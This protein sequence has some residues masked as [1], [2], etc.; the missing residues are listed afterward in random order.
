MDTVQILCTLRIVK[1]Y[2]GV[3][4]SDIPQNSITRSGTVIINAD[5]H[6]EKGSHWVAIHFLPRASSAYYFASYVNSPIVRTL[7]SFL[8]SNCAV[9][10]YNTVHLQGLTRTVYSQYCY[11]F[12]LNMD[13]CYTPKQF[14]RLFNA[15][16]ADRHI[17]NLFSTEFGLLWKEPRR[18]QYSHIIYKS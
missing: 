1:T 15:D 14:V 10:D 17:N 6:T 3:L 9:W 18:F 4:P 16:I 5:P 2:L 13:K 12:A 7:R 11:L 8:R